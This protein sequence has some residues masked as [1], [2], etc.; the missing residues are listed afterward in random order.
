M[1]AT[2]LPDCGDAWARAPSIVRMH[3]LGDVAYG[4]RE[5]GALEGSRTA[6]RIVAQSSASVRVRVN[7]HLELM[8]LEST[9]GNR[10]AFER[11]RTAAEEYRSRMSPSMSADYY[12]KLGMGLSR[13]DQATRA[14][15]ALST[16]LALAETHQLN[17][18]YFKV[19]KALEELRKPPEPMLVS[20]PDSAL[21]QAPSI[22][23]MEV[24]L[25]EYATA[26]L[27]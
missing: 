16:A 14:E 27:A 25:R 12:Y 7:A 21:S 2:L 24:E 9:F 22:V 13:F 18:W 6:F 4:L 19:E 17:A 20:Q 15:D 8:D 26:T 5:I 3:A 1:R 11:C 10:V 23:Q